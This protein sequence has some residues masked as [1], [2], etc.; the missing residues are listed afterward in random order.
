MIKTKHLISSLILLS[1]SVLFSVKLFPN[2]GPV[3]GSSLNSSGNIFL[4]NVKN[5]EHISEKLF[6]KTLKSRIDVKV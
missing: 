3:D 2:G 5:V 6:F 4:K 1:A